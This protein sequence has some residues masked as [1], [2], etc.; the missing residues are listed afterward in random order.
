MSNTDIDDLFIDLGGGVFLLIGLLIH[1]CQCEKNI[2]TRNKKINTQ[3]NQ[4]KF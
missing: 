1:K 2:F 3:D 4:E